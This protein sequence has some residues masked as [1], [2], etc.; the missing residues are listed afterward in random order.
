[1]SGIT[2][3]DS[4]AEAIPFEELLTMARNHIDACNAHGREAVQRCARELVQEKL[5]PCAGSEEQIVEALVDAFLVSGN[6]RR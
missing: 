6:G 4:Y 2:P 1:M 5:C 3:L